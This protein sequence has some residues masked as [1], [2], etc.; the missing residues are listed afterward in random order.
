MLWVDLREKWG[1]VDGNCGE[2]VY[3]LAIFFKKMIAISVEF[4]PHQPLEKDNSI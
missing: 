1:K 4:I 2:L 3:Q